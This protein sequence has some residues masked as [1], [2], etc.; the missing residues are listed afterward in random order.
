MSIFI[1]MNI[2][3]GNITYKEVFGKGGLAER[4]PNLKLN[5][6]VIDSWLIE[7]GAGHLIVKID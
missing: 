7:H 4:K 5:Q 3:E 1:A 2:R 6:E